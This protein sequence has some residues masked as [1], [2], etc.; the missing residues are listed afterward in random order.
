[1]LSR[2]KAYWVAFALWLLRPGFWI[3]QR[4]LSV[5]PQWDPML[6][7]ALAALCWL[8]G[9]YTVLVLIFSGCRYP[10]H[11]PIRS[12]AAAFLI[13]RLFVLLIQ[14]VYFPDWR[15]RRESDEVLNCA[16]KN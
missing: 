13:W 5:R 12:V 16:W 15:E 7:P 3:V 8:L 9:V 1:M 4:G 2:F 14:R 10:L 6:S 11:Y